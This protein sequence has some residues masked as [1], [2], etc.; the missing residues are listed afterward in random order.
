MKILNFD[1]GFDVYEICLFC[2]HPNAIFCGTSFF[3]FLG[4]CVAS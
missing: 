3:H 1:F 2:V 4:Q